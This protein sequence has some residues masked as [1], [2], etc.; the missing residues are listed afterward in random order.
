[1]SQENASK[2]QGGT[3]CRASKKNQARL[4]RTSGS[5]CPQC[6]FQIRGPGHSAGQHHKRAVKEGTPGM[7][8][9]F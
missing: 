5:Y 8:G 4:R 6:G 7:A 3:F 1:M 9:P 2:P